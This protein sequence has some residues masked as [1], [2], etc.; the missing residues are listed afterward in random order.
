MEM[1][2][3]HP[4]H[5]IGNLEPIDKKLGTVDYVN[6]ATPYTK[7]G[8]NT[9]TGGFSANGW[10]IT[11]IIIYLFIPFSQTREHVRP[12]ALVFSEILGGLNLH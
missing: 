4:P 9:H 11:K 7:F 3:F 10:N 2:K 8:T 12:V 1:D 6:E 5:K